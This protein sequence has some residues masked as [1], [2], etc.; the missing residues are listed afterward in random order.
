MLRAA[1]L[2]AL[3]LL[4][5]LFVA[6]GSGSAD[7]DAD[8]ASAVPA[9]AMLYAEVAI[10]PDGQLKDD[11]LDAAGKVLATDDPEGKL[12]EFLDRAMAEAEDTNLDYDKDIKPWLG[13]R[14][15][16]WVGQ[17]VD[18]DGDPGA[19]AVIA[20]TDT[21]AAMEAMRKA[22]GKKTTKRSYK[23]VDYEV[24]TDGEAAGTVDDFL[25]VGAEPEVKASIDAQKGDGLADS[26]RYKQSLDQLEDERLAHF[27]LDVKSFFNLAMK[28]SSGTDAQELEQLKTIFPFDKVPPVVGSFS[29]N[30]D[31]LALDFAVKGDSLKNLGALSQTYGGGTSPLLKEMPGDSWGALAAA[32]YGQ[33]LKSM[34]DQMAGAFGGAA[35]RRQLKNQL[36]IDLDQDV[37]SW[38][39][40]VGF[41]IRGDT[42]ASLDGAAVIQVTDEGKAAKGFGKLVGLLQSA[43]GVQAKP[44]KVDGAE[45][46]FAVDDPELPKPLILARSAE[47]VVVSYGAE[48]ARDAFTPASKL[49]DSDL[50][51]EAKDSLGGIEPS[52]LLAMPNVIKLVESSGSADAEFDKA[53]P[54][55]DAYDL[56]AYGLEGDE[57]EGHLRI[58]AGLK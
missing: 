40:D 13:E 1:T 57:D 56:I 22:D 46:A 53:R 3:S 9:N 31:R 37:L 41:F 30:G 45:A 23:G 11:A 50:Y 43:G 17:R 47:R 49:G 29:A 33:S 19:A 24:D 2:A 48:A 8:P 39:G 44:T 26:D 20:V 28:S 32:K 21:E 34:F 27:F 16:L 36:G 5:A 38:I 7:G 12:R 52:V 58:V 18:E 6:C 54:Y 15:A 10:Q 42:I 55:L 25:L 4:A 14:G 35:A 51:G